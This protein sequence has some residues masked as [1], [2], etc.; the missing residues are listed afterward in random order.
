[1]SVGNKKYNFVANFEKIVNDE[2]NCVVD[3]AARLLFK[4]LLPEQHNFSL[5][6]FC[7]C[8]IQLNPQ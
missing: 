6:L 4:T 8:V 7:N 1:M 3:R 5:E 2:L